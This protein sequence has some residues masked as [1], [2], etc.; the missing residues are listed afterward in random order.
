MVCVSCV[1]VGCRRL[2]MRNVSPVSSRVLRLESTRGQPLLTSPAAVLSAGNPSWMTVSF[3]ALPAGSS[4]KVTL[5]RGSP[6][7]AANDV[8]AHLRG[9]GQLGVKVCHV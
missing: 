6:A 3:T 1:S 4:S 7:A 9:S 2:S 5:D 8:L